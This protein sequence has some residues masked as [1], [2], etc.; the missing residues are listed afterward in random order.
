V[1]PESAARIH[2]NDEYRLLRALEVARLTGR[3][4]SA[5]PRPG[6]AE[7]RREYRFLLIGLSW[8][9]EELY[10]RI[11]RRAAAMFREGLPA[12]VRGLFQAG[13][14]PAD[15]GMRAIGYQEFFTTSP[16]GAVTLM[17]DMAAVEALVARNSR[18]Y[19]KRQITFFTPIPGVRW[20]NAGPLAA[21]ETSALVRAFLEGSLK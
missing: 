6:P 11:D 8:K 4:L 20:V 9:R 1:D 17:E 12:E 19:A 18:R 10:R 7:T 14:G 21:G 3:P 15:P 13:C 16:E 2:P 5:F